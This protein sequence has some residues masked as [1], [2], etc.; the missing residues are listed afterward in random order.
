MNLPD[1]MPY[2]YGQPE[3]T[4]NGSTVITVSKVRSRGGSLSASPVGV[5]VILDGKPT[6]EPA[7]DGGRIATIGAVTGLIAAAF[8]TIAMIRRPP[9]PDIS[10][11]EHR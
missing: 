5:F 3:Q 11:I 4:A 10:I 1:V 8:A 6:W 2:V 9:W 7:V